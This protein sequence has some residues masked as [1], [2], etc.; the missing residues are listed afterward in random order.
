MAPPT[1]E[2]LELRDL[3]DQLDSANK[4][5]DEMT[6]AFRTMANKNRQLLQFLQETK[7]ELEGVKVDIV[8]LKTASP[9][10]Q[11]YNPKV[12]RF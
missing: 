6:E 3:R 7:Q 1:K 8:N 10:G 4:R 5:L 9:N 11:N 12:Q 2:V